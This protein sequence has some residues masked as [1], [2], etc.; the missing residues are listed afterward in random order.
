MDGPDYRQQ[1]ELEEQQLWEIAH[2]C[3]SPYW[4]WPKPEMRAQEI[5]QDKEKS[6]E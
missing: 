3:C 5:Q 6:D 4:R 1:Q 2:G